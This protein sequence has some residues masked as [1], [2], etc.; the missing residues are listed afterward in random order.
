[1]L[2]AFFQDCKP[3]WSVPIKA[4][5]KSLPLWANIVSHFSEYWYFYILMGY[6]P[7]YINSVLQISL[8][9]VS[10]HCSSGEMSHFIILALLRAQNWGVTLRTLLRNC[11]QLP[12]NSALLPTGAEGC[13]PGSF[14]FKE[15]HLF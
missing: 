15:G 6:T 8:T 9:N 7:T 14:P 13:G 1:M 10:I 4:M 3:D 5:M 11:L 2:S 12:V